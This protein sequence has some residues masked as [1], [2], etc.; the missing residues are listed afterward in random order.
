MSESRLLSKKVAY[1][2]FILAGF[3]FAFICGAERDLA[4]SGNVLWTAAYTSRLLTASAF[5]G[6]LLGAAICFAVYYVCGGYPARRKRGGE[7]R[8]R[9]KKPAGGFFRLIGEKHAMLCSLVL[10]VLAWLPAYLAYYPGICAYDTPIQL[11]QI[12]DGY[13]IDHHPIAHT[14]LLKLAIW[15]GQTLWDSVNAGM[16]MYAFCQMVFLAFGFAYSVGTLKKLH[17]SGLWIC[18]M[19]LCVM[20]YPFNAY[21]AVSTTKDTV[22]TGFFLI[23]MSAFMRLLMGDG[24]SGNSLRI[25][26]DDAIF[27]IA[28]VGAI[29]FR[30]NYRYA[31]I[32]L[33]PFVF[34]TAAVSFKRK[35]DGKL[36][37]KL[38]LNVVLSLVVGSVTLTALF[39]LTNAEQGDRREMLSMPIQQFARCMLYHGGVGALPE[40][41]G[42]MDEESR[43]LINDF[44]L[45]EAYREYEPGFADPVKSHTN[46]YVA[47]YRAGD[48][49]GTYLRLLGE[50]PGDFINAALAL[51]AGYLYPGDESHAH[52]N[53]E[54]G[55]RGR[56]YVQTYWFESDLTPRGLTKDSKWPSLHERME[57]WA[58]E[59]AYLNIPLLKYIF[60][61]GT[62]LWLYV[63][64]AG[65]LLIQRKYRL[66]LP[67]M[68]AF[69]YYAT[70]FLGP[71]VQ[72]RYIF[73][74]MTALPFMA[75]LGFA[76]GKNRNDG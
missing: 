65:I 34:I 67:A 20:F 73:P 30:N 29:L 5:F 26:K 2:L 9:A 69:G 42:T 63:L 12:M 22:F 59:N 46:T 28:S 3:L 43:D 61:P 33:L 6:G 56:G 21:M 7:K 62:F 52:V 1:P 76:K 40:D 24:E 47:R 50:Y 36:F 35:K 32:V 19:Q 8:E 17:V 25:Q 72:L 58:D 4:E 53:E 68:L 55:K 75:L 18:V 10:S 66:L 31:I 14:L 39:H 11:G 15:L 74:L 49:I 51:D 70:L 48:F 44:L 57:D 16:G 23:M 71:T 45:D 13:M 54:E 37:A 38:F 64:F 41:D 27:F 60:V